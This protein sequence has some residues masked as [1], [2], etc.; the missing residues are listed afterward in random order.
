MWLL[1]PGSWV[2]AL[3]WVWSLLKIKKWIN[4]NRRTTFSSHHT[5]ADG[6]WATKAEKLFEIEKF[7]SGNMLCN[8]ICHIES[9]FFC[10]K[11]LFSF[12]RQRETEHQWGRS[13]ERGRHRIRGMFQAL[14]CQHWAQREAQTH[15]LWDHDLSQSRALNQ[16]SHPGARHIE[17]YRVVNKDLPHR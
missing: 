9:F 2:Q 17:S 13:R 16:L 15:E 8:R 5:I 7:W 11:L 3:C 1:I 10:F 12:V 14:S 4:K 6:S